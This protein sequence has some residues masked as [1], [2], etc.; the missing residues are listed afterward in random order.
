MALLIIAFLIMIM[1]KFPIFVALGGASVLAVFLKSETLMP[2]VTQRML[3]GLDSTPLMAGPFFVLAGAIMVRGK[4]AERLLT[5]AREIVCILPGG[6]GIAM[7]VTCAVFGAI[8]GSANAAILAIGPAMVPSI[9]KAYNDRSF[10]IGLITLSSTI[11]IIIPPSIPMVVYATLADLSIGRL[12][13][14]GFLP[15]LL[16]T[17]LLSVYAYLYGK[18]KHFPTEN[19]SL[20]RLGKALK[21]AALPLSMPV[22]VLGSIY[23]GIATPT[24]AA[25]ISVFYGLLIEVIIYRSFKVKDLKPIFLESAMIC[26]SIFIIIGCASVLASYLLL[27]G[28]PLRI[29]EAMF[30]VTTSKWV[31]LLG[32]NAF[33]L[34]IGCLMDIISAT[35]IFVPLFVG[36]ASVYGIDPYHFA[37]IFM[38]NMAIGYATPPVGLNLF[39]VSMVFDVPVSQIVKSVAF[40]FFMM[41]LATALITLFP[42]ITL[43]LIRLLM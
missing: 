3:H 33:L 21:D 39:V 43:F 32:V 9:A 41:L 18:I 31:F 23:S 37:L 20:I 1:L 5:L 26:G 10:A 8:S 28:I 4:S 29:A 11:A 24:E 12:F 19:I 38:V 34:V 42:D 6:L 40:P 30:K 16:I 25:V 35:Y 36:L 13:M 7:I 27:E 2:M 15:G 14:G 22:V 17:A